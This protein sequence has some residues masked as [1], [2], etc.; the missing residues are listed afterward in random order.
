MSATHLLDLFEYLMRGENASCILDATPT[1]LK[2]H[3]GEALLRLLT[4]LG[5]HPT[6]PALTVIPCLV[7]PKTRRMERL[8][9]L[10]TRLTIL[11]E[12]LVNAGGANKIDVCWRVGDEVAV[13]SS[14]IGWHSMK[15][16]AI[17]DFEIDPMLVQFTE[18]GGITEG[19]I[20]IPRESVKAY[21][22]IEKKEVA[23]E[24]AR[25]ARASNQV[26]KDN[27]NPL[28]I[29]DLNRMC[30]WLSLR[31]RD[32]KDK[33]P[34]NILSCCMETDLPP[35]LT[36]FHQNL[37]CAKARNIFRS[38]QKTVLI[39]ALPR[40]GKTYIGA[41]LAKSYTKILIL[42]TRP[43]ETLAQWEGVFKKH[44]DFSHA[45]ILTLQSGNAAQVAA[46]NKDEKVAL[47]CVA[48]I[49]F[50]KM[51]ERDCLLGLHWDLAIL[52]EVHAGGSTEL[53]DAMLNSYIG[54][55]PDKVMMTA[56]YTKPVDYYSIPSNS[57]CFWDLEDVRLM[58]RWGDSDVYARLC[59]KYGAEDVGCAKEEAYRC[60]FTDLQ[61]RASYESAPELAIF[62][63]M[64]QE[65]KYAELRTICKEPG[66]R[67][68]FSM[69]SLLMTT[70]DGRCFQHPRAVDTFLSLIT[71]AE[72][73]KHYPQGDM[74][75]FARIR[76]YWK[77]IGHR[78]GEEFM[79]QIWFLPSGVGQLLEHVKGAMIGRIQAHSVLKRFATMTLD[80]GMNDISR[81][82]SEAVLKAKADGKE[83]M[84]LLTGDVG[85]LGV[86]MPEVDV[87]FLLHEIESADKNYQQL[88]RVLTEAPGKRCG[89]V[90]DFNMWRVL[91]TLNTY[92]TSR[93]GQATK[94][95]A[96][97]IYWCVSH[98]IDVDPD[99][100]ACDESPDRHEK[101]AITE[102]MTKE[103]RRMIETTGNSLEAL[104]RKPFILAEEDQADL[105][106][107]ARAH[108]MASKGSRLA[109]NEENDQEELSSGLEQRSSGD[110]NEE[111]GEGEEVEEAEEEPVRKANLNDILAR[112]IPEIALLSGCKHDLLEAVSEIQKTPALYT[113][114]ND[115]LV[116][117]QSQ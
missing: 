41:A 25:K 43:S 63:C 42:T 94:S 113:A 74:S 2:G 40:S 77:T 101:G 34:L 16:K 29:E 7:N 45:T 65:E 53:S 6:N 90:V 92:A 56:T 93:C 115:F 3:V 109:V 51:K 104:A 47:I 62:T 20:R 44:R 19:G 57:C 98:L 107:I 32:C 117:M 13:C 108:Q 5:I 96:E 78:D 60:G 35:L 21:V 106:R 12:G 17:A 99:L 31:I 22:L 81:S 49:Q 66:E 52:D 46:Y 4:L 48:S 97:R 89:A 10:S 38:G 88:M 73:M 76:R 27:F 112:L 91:T 14:K 72:K 95:S 114:L 9:D 84:I 68:G 37:L 100:W 70:K 11:K 15:G 85:S 64:M 80:A 55:G 69:R 36:R 82:V 79:T 102:R 18:S 116:Q 1:A 39:G 30:A 50:F 26:S 87:G 24:I 103:W 67:Y 110:E 111:K 83:G 59:E 28:D 33:G 58:R 75:I 8:A 54:P 105:D 71:G 23:M 86:S 61:I